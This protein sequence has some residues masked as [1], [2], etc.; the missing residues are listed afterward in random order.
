MLQWAWDGDPQLGYTYVIAT[1][2]VG[3]L[4][5]DNNDG[6]VDLCD[7]PDVVVVAFHPDTL[8]D[9]N[10]IYGLTARIYILDGATGA[11][12]TRF[13]DP[14]T[15]LSSPALADIDQDGEMEIIASRTVLGNVTAWNADGTKVQGFDFSFGGRNRSSLH[16]PRLRDPRERVR[17]RR[18]WEPRDPDPSLHLQRTGSTSGDP[19]CDRG[20]ALQRPRRRR[21]RS[22]WRTGDHLGS[23]CLDLG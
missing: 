12:H 22:R 23:P 18:R 9:P 11:L 2:L 8:T 20:G 16:H 5:D 19:G 10:L 17:P 15:W 14:M 1:P 13:E 6:V 3:N 21:S 7:T 4:T